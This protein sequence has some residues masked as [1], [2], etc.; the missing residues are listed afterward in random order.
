M[1]KVVIYGVGSPI[2]VDVEESLFRAGIIIVAGVMNYAGKSFLSAAIPFITPDEINDQLT[3]LPF[4]VP[5]FT[6]GN[7]QQAVL[8][9]RQKGFSHPYTLIDSTSVIPRSLNIESGGY[10]N[11]GCSLGAHSDFGSFVFINRGVSIG[12]HAN[13]AHFVSIGP[14]AVVAGSVTIGVGAMIGAGSVVLPEITI[15]ENSVIGAGSVVTRHVPAHCLVMGNPARIV[16]E[17]I[18]GYKEIN[19]SI[20]K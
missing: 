15:G 17:N 4:I 19:V 11:A 18:A 14:G 10:I 1:K 8:E 12:H 7:R 2:L 6:P 5:F 3:D 9:A 20:S 16:K 13:I